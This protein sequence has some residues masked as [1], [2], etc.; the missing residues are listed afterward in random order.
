MRRVEYDT[1]SHLLALQDLAAQNLSVVGPTS[2]PHPGDIAHWIHGALRAYDPVEVVPVWV[3]DRGVSAFGVLWPQYGGV[4]LCVRPDVG[5]AVYQELFRL[6]LDE[7]AKGDHVEVDLHDGDARG[8]AVAAEL[9]F[10]KVRSVFAV[11][12]QSLGPVQPIADSDYEIRCASYEEFAEIADVHRSAFGSTWTPDEYRRYMST[13]AYAPERE[14]IAVAPDG[15]LAGFAV[16]WMDHLNGIGY[17]EPVGVHQDHHRKRVG[18]D[19]LAAGM[20]LMRDAGMRTA[21]VL[22]DLENDGNARFYAE[23]GFKRI[24]TVARYERTT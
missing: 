9:G 14:L 17:F 4:D 15:S 22:Y 1:H 21:T 16:C 18:S 5:D 19:L 8:L 6:L 20:N 23:N 11:N 13:P 10:M 12:A 3:D 7:A 2:G 24:E